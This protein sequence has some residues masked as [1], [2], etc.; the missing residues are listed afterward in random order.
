VFH[1][2]RRSAD[3][4]RH[5]CPEDRAGDMRGPGARRGQ[6]VHS[7]QFPFQAKPTSR[8]RTQIGVVAVAEPLYADLRWCLAVGFFAVASFAGFLLAIGSSISFCPTDAFLGFFAGLDACSEPTLRRNASIRST[9]LPAA[10]RSFGVIGLPARFRLMRSIR[11]VSEIER[12]RSQV[13]RQRKE[14]L[15][16]QRAGIPTASAEALIGRMLAKIDDLCVQRDE[17]N[18][19]QPGPTKGKS[20]A[21][22]GPHHRVTWARHKSSRAVDEMRSAFPDSNWAMMERSNNA[23]SRTGPD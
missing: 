17:L 22:G 10:G 5:A 9:T 16:L 20:W 12:M 8:L 15:Q 19:N 13:S 1:A 4:R 11:A 21:A 7:E 3:R 23:C 2:D 6:E 18:R 14:I